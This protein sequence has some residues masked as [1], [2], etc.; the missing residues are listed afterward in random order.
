M[1]RRFS[2]YLFTGILLISFSYSQEIQGQ[3]VDEEGI[4]V[5]FATIGLKGT[6]IGTVADINGKF[7]LSLPRPGIHQLEISSSGSKVTVLEVT[8]INGE[9]LKLGKIRL[10][11]SIGQL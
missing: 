3:I 2:I 5:P 1:K 9:S 7:S 6:G 11:S 10:E 4:E 8:I